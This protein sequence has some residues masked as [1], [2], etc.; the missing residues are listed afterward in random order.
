MMSYY[1]AEHRRHRKQIGPVEK[2][3]A[4]EIFAS[5]LGKVARREHLGLLEESG[6][7]FEKFSEQWLDKQT[8]LKPRS[9]DR[10]EEVLR[11]HLRPFF[12]GPLKMVT[13]QRLESYLAKRKEDG[14]AASTINRERSVALMLMKTAVRWEV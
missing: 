11:L 14:A 8:H 6:I 10:W 7:T 4:Q 5:T 1:D 13:A 12:K 9:K 3:V 2:R